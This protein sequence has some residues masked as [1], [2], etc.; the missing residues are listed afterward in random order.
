MRSVSGY[1]RLIVNLFIIGHLI[2]A[3][4]G[5]AAA[6]AP[7]PKAPKATEWTADYAGTGLFRIGRCGGFVIATA[8]NSLGGGFSW[9]S[10]RL[11]DKPPAHYRIDVRWRRLSADSD[12]T[13]EVFA[14]GVG[15][16]LADGKYGFYETDAQF[17]TDGWK[18]LPS[19]TTLREH[20]IALERKGA[21]LTLH[22][23]GRL[24]ASYT[25][26]RAASKGEVR[27]GLKGY[28]ATRARVLVREL[29]VTELEQ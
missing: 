10:I 28:G 16:L 13:L 12:R 6:E 29:S 4:S 8:G 3:L 21:Q 7:C 22:V 20:A 17:A 26:K 5:S 27:L 1:L 2:T 19:Y 11:R 25:L 18:R 9:G 23:D 15:V 24:V 14:H